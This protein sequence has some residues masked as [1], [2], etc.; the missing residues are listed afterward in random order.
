MEE[1]SGEGQGL[2]V[3]VWATGRV[4]LHLRVREQQKKERTSLASGSQAQWL[5]HIIPTTQEDE[6]LSP[7]KKLIT[8]PSQPISCV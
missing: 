8:T 5:K 4:C 7:S 6:G 3:L 2:S 1:E